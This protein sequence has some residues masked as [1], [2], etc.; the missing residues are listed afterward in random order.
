MPA[1]PEQSRRKP[2]FFEGL[3]A[4]VA[5]EIASRKVLDTAEAAS[6]WGV[7]VMTW[8]RLYREGRVPRPILIS[9]RK[10]GWRLG[11][12]MAVQ[13]ARAREVA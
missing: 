9:A 7:S 6:F 10:Y 3:D 11:D 8:R 2:S 1:Q 4:S 12:L 13:D 5:R